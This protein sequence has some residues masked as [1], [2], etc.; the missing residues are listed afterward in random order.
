MCVHNKQTCPTGCTEGTPVH[1]TGKAHKDNRDQVS[2]SI[3]EQYVIANSNLSFMINLLEYSGKLSWK[4]QVEA[5]GKNLSGENSLATWLVETTKRCVHPCSTKG[6]RVL[7]QEKRKKR[8]FSSSPNAVNISLD[9]RASW[10]NNT[11]KVS[12]K[13]W[14]HQKPQMNTKEQG[15]NT[16]PL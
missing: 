1:G 8:C 13:N 16:T 9:A 12:K 15:S 7:P 14:N 4:K 5:S 3:L 2:I 6:N 10:R 11:K